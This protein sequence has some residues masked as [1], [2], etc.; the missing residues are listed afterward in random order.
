MESIEKKNK[1]FSVVI[2]TMWKSDLITDLIN[3]YNSN[4]LI[5]EIL[6]IDNNPK[7]RKYFLKTSKIKIITNNKNNFVNPSWNLGYTL[8]K[9]KV[10]LSNDDIKIDK[11]D[12][13]LTLLNKTKYDLV[14][15]QINSESS[16]MYIEDYN[17]EPNNNFGCFIYCKNYNYIPEKY[18]IWAGDNFLV[19]MSEKVGILIN[20][21]IQTTKSE[22]LKKMNE[23]KVNVAELDRQLYL[24]DKKEKSKEIK[25]ILFV[26]VNYGD[27]QINFLKEVVSEIKKFKK[28]ETK[29]ILHSNIETNVEGIDNTIIF[30]NL[31]DYQLLPL[32]C[33]KTIWENRENFDVFVYGENDHL[34]K[35]NHIDKHIEYSKILPEDRIS[36]LIQYEQNDD[37]LFY[38]A[39][40]AHYEWE[41]DNIE[42]YDNK[43]FAHFTNLHQATF[44]LTQKQLHKIGY[45][46]DFTKFFG[47]SHYSKKCKVNTDLYQFTSYKK[48]ICISEFKENL[49]HH[50]PNLYIY[51]D[52]GR[53]KNQR[54]DDERMKL[55]LI[56]L[57]GYEIESMSIENNYLFSI[58]LPTF[59]NIEFIDECLNS[60]IKSSLG[61]DYEIL[62]GIDNCVKTINYIKNKNY[63]SNIKFLFFEKNVGPYV[64]KNSLAK[65]AKSEIL[66]FFDSDDLM[67]ENMVNRILE[68]ITHND[69]VK[70]MYS[71]FTNS[72][73]YSISES[74]TFGEGV[75]C[76]K[77]DIFLSMNGFEP[78]PIAADSE[79]MI[80]LYK[81]NIKFDYTSEV[82]FFRRKHP[83]SLTQRK[84][85]N[86]NSVL[87]HEYHKKTKS[88]KYFGPL[89]KL[90]TEKF[91]EVTTNQEIF[92]NNKVIKKDNSELLN[93]ILNQTKQTAKVIDYDKI[94][95]VLQK[96][97]Y[98]D[99][100]KPKINQNKPKDRQEI[101]QLKKDSLIATNRKLLQVKSNKRNDLPNI[102][103]K[104]K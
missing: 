69:F 22:T 68:K 92:L 99:P 37:G 13:I 77:K 26:L 50:L 60:I 11:L 36:G 91:I 42:K 67:K 59:D 66:L 63:T 79:F 27:E 40:H 39:Y 101:I 47:E 90:H 14:G 1:F 53:K 94:S 17:Q 95:E 8:S 103:S 43:V 58:I 104:K 31:P 44:I 82:V 88:K 32:T 15:V 34:F 24:N 33:R 9:Y 10:I 89:E 96:D 57:L 55:S 7:E 65:I 35:E 38:P 61:Y 83:N 19:K 29:I 46:H 80:R 16:D 98:T 21:S 18:K 93:S 62:I 100:P 2:P 12:E 49:I 54:S 56:K 75:F 71:D 76:I 52:K 51:G 41:F 45:E 72:P 25:K 73:N 23:L 81:N 86:Y 85:T 97:T 84:E 102:F 74:S 70:P 4:Q 48:L 20:S 87:R 6:I 28:Y 78:W 5:K 64:V 30:D 3:K